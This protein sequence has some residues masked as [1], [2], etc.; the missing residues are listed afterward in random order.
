M[1]VDAVIARDRLIASDC[2]PVDRHGEHLSA[3]SRSTCVL[4]LSKYAPAQRTSVV[5]FLQYW[6]VTTIASSI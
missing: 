6:I 2:L 3:R 5:S 1:R 4:I